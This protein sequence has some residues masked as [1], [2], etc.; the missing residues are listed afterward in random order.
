[1]TSGSLNYEQT[2]NMATLK[3]VKARI[4]SITSIQKITKSMKLVATT[5]LKKAEDAFK[6]N[7]PSLEQLEKFVEDCKEGT[8]PLDKAAAKEKRSGKT[9]ISCLAT[10]R[11]LCGSVNSSVN[12]MMRNYVKDYEEKKRTGEVN[13][14]LLGN[15]SIQAV[16]RECG[17]NTVW[18]AK[19]IGGR[20][21]VTFLDILPVAERLSAE[22]FENGIFVRNKFVNLLTFNTLEVP[23]LSS[24]QFQALRPYKYEHPSGNYEEVMKNFH[25]WHTAIALYRYFFVIPLF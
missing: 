5:R 15:K 7:K 24:T 4:R 22:E 13:F 1:M 2:R 9:L 11:G 12:R 10:E 21:G 14:A 17:P 25:E 16:S 8:E 23:M 3:E 19:S 18:S 6:A 20:N